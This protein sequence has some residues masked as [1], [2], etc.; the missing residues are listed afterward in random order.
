MVNL[1]QGHALY[2][3]VSKLLLDAL[4]RFGVHIARMLGGNSFYPDDPAFWPVACSPDG[5]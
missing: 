5:A 2:R 4:A 1:K 3:P